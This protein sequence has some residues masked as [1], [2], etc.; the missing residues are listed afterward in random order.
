MTRREHD[1]LRHQWKASFRRKADAKHLLE[2]GGKHHTRGAM[3]LGGY[4]IECKLKALAME[5][6]G[7]STLA[8]LSEVL[9]SEVVYAH[10]LEPLL[11][12]LGLRD[13]LEA[14]SVGRDFAREVNPWWASWR[15][16]PSNP[17]VE[18][19]Q[20]FMAAV[21]RIFDWLEANRF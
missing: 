9:P 10:K 16:D 13:K 20:L 5:R 2:S 12:H 18:K 8:K 21:D 4:A 3:Y 6:F 15:Y 14:S 17:P 7:C 19:A 1:N 11:N